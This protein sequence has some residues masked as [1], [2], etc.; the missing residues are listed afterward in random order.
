MID[1][2]K[3][4]PINDTHGHVFGDSV[5]RSVGEFLQANIR[6]TDCVGRYGG[7]EFMIVLPDTPPEGARTLASRILEKAAKLNLDSNGVTVPIRMSVG[8]ATL[9]PQES[10]PQYGLLRPDVLERVGADLI[11]KADAQLYL[12]K[13]TGELAE[14]PLLSWVRGEAAAA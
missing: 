1:L 5:L 4:K 8:A 6:D 13:G 11:E 10:G 9:S 12:K 14:I 7:D 2:D 3:F